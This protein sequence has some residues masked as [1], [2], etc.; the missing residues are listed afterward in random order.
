MNNPNMPKVLFP[1]RTQ[2]SSPTAY[3]ILQATSVI[4]ESSLH[5]RK[6]AELT[7]RLTM[8]IRAYEDKSPCALQLARV[9]YNEAISQ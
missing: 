1:V 8:A 7:N 9:V 3:K 4:H 6:R 5:P 2:G